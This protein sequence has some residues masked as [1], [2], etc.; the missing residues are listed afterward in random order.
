MSAVTA[1]AHIPLPRYFRALACLGFL[2][3]HAGAL[4]LISIRPTQIYAQDALE[5]SLISAPA[6]L[7]QA[8]E[9][10]PDEPQPVPETT[11]SE[12]IPPDAPAP[13]IK[14]EKPRPKIIPPKPKIQHNVRTPAHQ[15]SDEASAADLKQARAS[16]ASIVLARINAAKFYPAEARK[17]NITG[18]VGVSFS[19]G[20]DGT[21]THASLRASSGS[22]LLDDAALRL[23]RGLRAPPPPE[24][25]YS[26][27]TTIR[28]SL[29]GR[30]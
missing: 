25:N 2:A 3:L 13:Q 23:L 17:D 27:A 18:N 15:M 26:A 10:M 12:A 30:S 16:Y 9:D 19:I 20:A 1:S 29:G 14:Q 6:P 28:Y 8:P 4:A 7:Q 24:G 11:V 21:V 5:V 22:S